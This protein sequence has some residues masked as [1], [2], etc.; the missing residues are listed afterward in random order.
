M[1][2]VLS[3][4][5]VLSEPGVPLSAAGPT[6]FG[7]RLY[8][9]LHNSGES[10]CL[11]SH[12]QNRDLVREWLLREGFSD[13]VK[14]V[15]RDDT[16]QPP[17]LWKVDQVRALVAH[18]QHIMYFVDHDPVVVPAMAEIGVPVML[19]VH[20][21]GDPGRQFADA[22]VVYRSWDSLVDTIE[23]ESLKRAE[24]RRK[25]RETTGEA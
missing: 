5:D 3:V 21:W 7:R 14:L 20:P 4:E 24:I 2:V 12:S 16:D 10:L 6:L 9:T 18:G 22:E 11:I 13:Y 1:I 17:D 15:T 25:R 23:T 8:T 19:V